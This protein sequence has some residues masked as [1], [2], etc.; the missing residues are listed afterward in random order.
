MYQFYYANQ[1]QKYRQNACVDKIQN[2]FEITAIRPTMWEEHCLECSAPLCYQN[3]LHYVAR[4]DGRCKRF[5]NG[6]W[7][8][9]SDKACCGQGVH[10][11]FRKWA[12]MMT[13][14]FPDMIPMDS[15]QKLHKKNQKLGN[16]LKI[17]ANSKLPT[18]VRW[19]I[20]R[21]EE[22]IR[23]RKLRMM[24]TTNNIPDAFVFHGYSYDKEK[25][26]LII[27]IYNDHTPVYKTALPIVPGENLYVL[28][29]EQ[30]APECWTVNYLVKIYPENDIEAELDILWCD[31]VCGKAVASEKS[32]D[33]VKCV[34][35]DL[36][37]TVW[38]GTLI[39]TDDLKKLNLKAGV[40]ET[41][42][43]LDRRG[44]IQSIA[45]KND[46]EAAWPVVEN[47]G[48]AEYFLY[49][50]IHWNAK[51]GSVEQIAKSLNIGID[52]LALIDDSIFERQ[53]VRSQFPQVRTYDVSELSNLLQLPEFV[54]MVTEESKKRRAMYQA[55]K[56]RNEIMSQGNQGTVEFLK[57]CHLTIQLF[58]PETENQVMRCYELVVRTNQ[59]NMSG[60]K[61]SIEE[62]NEV[63]HRSEHKNFAFSCHDDFGEYG[64]VGFGQYRVEQEKL[65]FTEFVMSCRVAGKYVESALFANLLKKESCNQG[66]F[67]VR[68][69]K[70][71]ALLRRTLDD[72]GFR[73]VSY[74]E[75]KVLYEFSEQLK[76][77]ELVSCL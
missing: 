74:D 77:T 44:I 23:R 62:F 40:L 36:D 42:Q 19:E 10:I 13:I 69:T 51:S 67:E 28:N 72:I 4:S 65:I 15:Y 49:P 18:K 5:E 39:E 59:L 26:N 41:I 32:A 47:L 25:Y 76:Y 14:I 75:D 70:K 55:E 27:E 66:I 63:L 20:I 21:T 30:L 71:N 68:K 3:C 54:V 16:R 43:E 9:Q 35:W 56:K 34:V 12:N 29:R 11:K 64:I 60:K 31:F 58:S 1:K 6:F 53:Q 22:Y 24:E 17:V 50:Q 61:Y 73:E 33:K 45:S 46:M 57:K 8:F 38:D 2:H 48:I 37:N 7:T 52:S